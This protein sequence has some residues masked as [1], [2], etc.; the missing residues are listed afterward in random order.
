MTIKISLR[1]KKV[2]TIAVIFI[3]FTITFHLHFKQSSFEAKLGGQD[4]RAK[5]RLAI[6]V[7]FRDRFDELI[8]FVPYLSD[9]IQQQQSTGS[10]RIHVINQSARYRF[11]RGALVNVGYKL[12]KDESDYIAIHDVD[13]I[14][15]NKNLSYAYPELGPYH[16]T[17]PEYH[18]NYNYDKYI[19]GILL[20]NNEHFQLVNGFSNRYFGWGLEDDEFYTRLKAANLPISRPENLSTNKSNTFLHFHY[21]RKRDTFKT[22]KQ[23]ESLKYRDKV[24]GLNSL[25]FLLKSNHTMTIDKIYPFHIYNVELH[26]DIQ[27]TPWCLPVADSSATRSQS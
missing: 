22:K 12:V 13:L 16:M 15:M 26:C 19:G 1:N 6:I 8:S 7:P 20:I 14:P 10:F 24:T 21:N 18:P 3:L 4:G 5:S 11:N 9:F 23:R 27:Q 2:L 25:K 17:S